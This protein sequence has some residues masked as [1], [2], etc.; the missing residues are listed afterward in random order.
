MVGIEQTRAELVVNQPPVY[1]ALWRKTL[2]PD[3]H[4]ISTTIR[5]RHAE[6]R[7][8]ISA[9][10]EEPAKA[11]AASPVP[12]DIACYA[13]DGKGDFTFPMH[14]CWS[15][16]DHSEPVDWSG[17]PAV[18]PKTYHTVTAEQIHALVDS[19]ALFGRKFSAHCHGLWVRLRGVYATPEHVVV[20]TPPPSWAVPAPINHGSSDE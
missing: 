9:V 14:V 8:N 1:M 7:T 19:P 11:S 4:F 6:S 5:F 15:D 3:E 20:D 12:A 2:V 10:P 17:E 16:A 18:R 13:P